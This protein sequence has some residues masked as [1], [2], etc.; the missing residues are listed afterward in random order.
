MAGPARTPARRHRDPTLVSTECWPADPIAA[1]VLEAEHTHL[2]ERAVILVQRSTAVRTA[3]HEILP[4][5]VSQD[6]IWQPA[7]GFDEVEQAHHG[8]IRGRARK[9]AH[10]GGLFSA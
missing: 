2:A 3:T 6:I 10:S 5:T 4:D 9:W 7:E 1:L 8:E